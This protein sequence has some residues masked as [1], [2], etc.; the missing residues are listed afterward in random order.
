LAKAPAVG[1][2][3]AD[4]VEHIREEEV[5]RTDLLRRGEVEGGLRVCEERVLRRRALGKLPAGRYMVGMDMS[6]DD[7][8]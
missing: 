5:E 1:K 7:I 6:V 3:L 4:A 8:P 2:A